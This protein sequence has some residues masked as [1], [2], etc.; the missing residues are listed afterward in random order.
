MALSG[1]NLFKSLVALLPSEIRQSILRLHFHKKFTEATLLDEPELAVIPALVRQGDTVFDIGANFGLF[2]KFLSQVAGETGRVFAFEPG[3]Q[4]FDVLSR[5]VSR[6][7]FANVHLHQTALSDRRGELNFYIP[8]RSDGTLNFYEATLEKS[9]SGDRCESF[10]VETVPLDSFV[11]SQGIERVDFIKCDVEGHEIDVLEGAK[12]T[13]REHS[14]V[15]FLEV[16]APLD[17]DGHG[18][19]VRERIEAIGYDIY[20]FERGRFVEWSTGMTPKINYV[21]FPRKERPR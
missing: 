19:L 8:R 20:F 5:N 14:P 17:D 12:N 21:L 4:M 6:S 9:L 7:C 1:M 15:I 13:I 2:T 3:P 11:E 18:A 16:N 10:A